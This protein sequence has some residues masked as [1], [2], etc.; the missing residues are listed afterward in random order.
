MGFPEL[1]SASTLLTRLKP[2]T[3]WLL[4]TKTESGPGKKS[5]RTGLDKRSVA[6]GR[7]IPE[8]TVVAGEVGGGGLG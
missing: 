6:T 5:Y 8:G 4:G 7:L 2:K 1:G 3:N